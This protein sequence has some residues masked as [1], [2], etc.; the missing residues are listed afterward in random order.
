MKKKL[1]LLVSCS[2]F[3]SA[4][5]VQAQIIN[6]GFETWSADA[7]VPTAM[8]PNTG[9][10]ST[11]WWDFNLYNSSFLGSSPISV[12]RVTD[13]VHSGTYAARIESKVYT[14]TSWNIYNS[15]G[16]PF[17]G[18][19]YNDTLGILFNG[20]V[21]VSPASYAPGIPCS[22]K[23]TQYKF[24]Y[25]Y[26]P[27][28]NDTAE[29]RVALISS[30]TL[31]AGGVFKTNAATS[32]WQ[33]ATINFAYISTLTPDTLYVLYSAASLDR[34]PKAHS[35]LWIDDVTVTLP[36]GVEEGLDKENAIQ[37]FPNPSNG[38][39]SVAHQM[40]SGKSQTVE[41]YNLVG[42]L[43]WSETGKNRSTFNINI[44]QA[45][46]GIYFVRFNDGERVVMEKVVV[47]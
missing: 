42:E 31:V 7:L 8:N 38:N 46:K 30:G 3:L 43:I 4:H 36:T 19:P 34:N 18:H 20:N 24:W 9:N 45:P 37:I 41:V 26:N 39:F 15:Y 23:L 40:N 1:L 28:G 13:T 27:N 6:P 16:I 17:I 33:Q 29:C 12:T 10:G 2:A 5:I 14:P 25:Q 22:S 11:G 21:N 47:E 32:G 35:V 44:S